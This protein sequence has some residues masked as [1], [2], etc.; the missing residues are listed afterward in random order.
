MSDKKNI[1]KI[2]SDT[3]NVEEKKFSP[4]RPQSSPKRPQSPSRRQIKKPPPIKSGFKG[5]IKN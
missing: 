5:K 2:S 3:N 1:Q 4:K